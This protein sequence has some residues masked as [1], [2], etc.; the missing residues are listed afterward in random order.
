MA[1]SPFQGSFYELLNEEHPFKYELRELSS[2]NDPVT[3]CEALV[4]PLVAQIFGYMHPYASL[5]TFNDIMSKLSEMLQEK[6]KGRDLHVRMSPHHILWTVEAVHKELCKKYSK[7]DI[8]VKLLVLQEK[9]C[10]TIVDTL[11]KHLIKPKKKAGIRKFLR[12]V[13]AS[14]VNSLSSY[15]LL[16]EV[17]HNDKWQDLRTQKQNWELFSGIDANQGH[18]K[19]Q[20]KCFMILLNK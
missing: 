16:D 4:P 14:M 3:V 20:R 12:T 10:R 9:L 7:C 5:D 17:T 18:Q 13:Y 8:I 15:K 19:F 1:F 6:L 2:T 11:A